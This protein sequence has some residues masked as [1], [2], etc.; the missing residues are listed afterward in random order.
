MKSTCCIGNLA[1]A[2]DRYMRSIIVAYT[3]SDRTIGR[4]GSLPW[5]LPKDMKWFRSMTLGKTVV[6]G[7]KTYES[8]PCYPQG[9]PARTN[10]VLSTTLKTDAVVVAASM[11]EVMQYVGDREVIF[12][13]G[14][15]LYQSALPFVDTVFA[16]EIFA[17][18]KGD[19]HFP[20]LEGNW[21]PKLV[22]ESDDFRVVSYRRLP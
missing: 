8:L 22:L 16:T 14:E 15:K 17:N 10:I 1:G 18:Y 2:T 19:T 9:L 21:F 7:R 6:M 20:Q 11:E 5:N 12:I 3:L 13:G 4:A